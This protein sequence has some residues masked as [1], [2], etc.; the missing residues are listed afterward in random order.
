MAKAPKHLTG[1]R[2]VN[3]NRAEAGVTDTSRFAA[4]RPKHSVHVSPPPFAARL[5]S[6]APLVQLHV[7]F[8]RLLL[9]LS[10][11][12]PQAPLICLTPLSDRSQQGVRVGTYWVH[13]RCQV[14][15]QARQPCQGQRSLRQSLKVRSPLEIKA[16]HSRTSV[17]SFYSI[18]CSVYWQTAD[19]ATCLPASRHN[20]IPSTALSI[21]ESCRRC[22]PSAAEMI[23]LLSGCDLFILPIK[24]ISPHIVVKA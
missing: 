17:S 3:T 6:A 15:Q 23:A 8:V 7:C 22:P 9:S 18:W 2:S 24:L 20:P 1:L 16:Q 13:S 4:P 11:A 21:L 10:L 14:V 19:G 5:G 12:P